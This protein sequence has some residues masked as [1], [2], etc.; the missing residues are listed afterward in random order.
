MRKSVRIRLFH[1]HGNDDV[2]KRACLRYDDGRADERQ[3]VFGQALEVS[4]KYMHHDPAIMKDY[5][6][7]SCNLDE[8]GEPKGLLLTEG[9]LCHG[10]VLCINRW[11]DGQPLLITAHRREDTQS[12]PA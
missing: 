10:L 12:L 1:R 7:W 6:A 2:R 9:V 3:D 4:L 5:F 8:Q 11:G